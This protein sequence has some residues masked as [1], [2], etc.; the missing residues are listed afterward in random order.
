MEVE[1]RSK[2]TGQVTN[3]VPIGGTLPF[4]TRKGNLEHLGIGRVE[5]QRD[6][7]WHTCAVY[8]YRQALKKSSVGCVWS[9]NWTVDVYEHNLIPFGCKRDRENCPDQYLL[10]PCQYISHSFWDTTPMIIRDLSENAHNVCI[11]VNVHIH[12]KNFIYTVHIP[13]KT[14]LKLKL[15]KGWSFLSM[16]MLDIIIYVSVFELFLDQRKLFRQQLISQFPS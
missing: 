8:P 4:L 15:T 14:I 16:D 1:G 6:G 7:F 13:R 5:G 11:V 9:C 10:T 12:V 2:C 3:C